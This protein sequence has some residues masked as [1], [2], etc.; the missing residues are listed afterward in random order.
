MEQQC[1][2]CSIVKK[3]IP[4]FIVYEDDK[5]LAILDANPAIR[6][7]VLVLP[8]DH[9]PIFPIIPPDVINNISNAIKLISHSMLK[10]L[11]ADGT[12]IF[13]ANG[14]I[15]GQKSG[16]AL[17]HIIPR[18]ENDKITSFNIPNEKINNSELKI[19]KKMFIEK[20][21]ELESKSS[22]LEDKL[23]EKF[24]KK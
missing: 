15:A 18:Y 9:Y 2:F 3:Q 22:N 5:V 24:E 16:H 8:K 23:N 11:N 19:S 17:V 6:G 4:S 12:T 10:S 13:I 1:I 21:K 20:L 7:H 14:A